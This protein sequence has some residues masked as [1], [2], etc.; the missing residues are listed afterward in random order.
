MSRGPKDEKRPGAMPVM[1]TKCRDISCACAM[2]SSV[3]Q[4]VP[5]PMRS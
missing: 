3:S 5:A 2:C 4:H 1:V